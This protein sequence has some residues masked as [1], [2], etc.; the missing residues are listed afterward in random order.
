MLHVD[1]WWR[2]QNIALDPGTFSYNART[3]GQRARA[4]R[5]SQHG[6]GRRSSQMDQAGRFLWLPWLGSE[7]RRRHGQRFAYFEGGHDGYRRLSDPVT[8]RR[9][10]AR[11][12]DDH[13]LVLDS[14]EGDCITI[15]ASL[16]ADRRSLRLGP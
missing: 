9:G 2:G 3:V 4:N 6:H 14:L 12:G 1:L 13:W 10:I 11:L 8:H 5:L 7:V 16:A 15:S